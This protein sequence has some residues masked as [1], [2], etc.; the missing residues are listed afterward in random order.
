MNGWTVYDHPADYPQHFVARRWIARG[1]AVI[2]TAE[3]FTADSLEELRA[4]L[5]PGLIVFPRS[6]SDDP[7]IVEC[8]M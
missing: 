5:P 6:P 8:W 2:A 1:G 4:L 7:T 3:M